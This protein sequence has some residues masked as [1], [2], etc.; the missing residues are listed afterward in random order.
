VSVLTPPGAGAIAT[1]AVVGLRA[2]EWT[3]RLFRPAGKMPL[4]ELP[5]RN[6]IWFGRLGAGAG[7]EVVLAVRQVDPEPWVEIHCHGGRRGVRWV[8]EQFVERGCSESSWAGLPI[9][10]TPSA[11]S[12]ALEPLTRAST[13]RTAS[14][15]LDQFHGAFAQAVTTILAHLD[16]DRIERAARELREL[17]S[18]GPIGR[19]LVE[20]WRVVIAGPPNVGKSSLVNALAGY[21]RSVVS[22]V[23]GTTRDVV[24]VPVAFDGW[25]VELAD[26]AGLRD[27]SGLEAEG[28]ERAKRVLSEADVCVWVLDATAV[29]PIYPDPDTEQVVGLPMPQWVLVV[30]KIDQPAGWHLPLA[31]GAIPVS[32]ATGEGIPE[33][34]SRIVFRLV[35]HA[36]LP[37]VAVPFTPSL[38]DLIEAAH[39]ALTEGRAADAAGLLRAALPGG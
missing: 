17:D 29:D 1:V 13:T 31:F 12:R 25:P 38:A 14:I 10:H 2:W 16:A 30:N 37:G 20:P 7:D 39:A 18:R 34:I 11:D 19:H 8:V 3:R 28:V 22:E 5:E 36:P 27:A 26:T 32:A 23:A 21:Q 6:R 15:L 33:L 24:T 4:P 9:S 35:P